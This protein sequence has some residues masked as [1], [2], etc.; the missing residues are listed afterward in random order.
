M[1]GSRDAADF[2]VSQVSQIYQ[3]HWSQNFWNILI[4]NLNVSEYNLSN[5]L[6]SYIKPMHLH[7]CLSKPKT[8][9][10]LVE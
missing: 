10:V 5:I 2:A 1:A 7:I 8:Q 6:T 4:Q 9:S 3:N